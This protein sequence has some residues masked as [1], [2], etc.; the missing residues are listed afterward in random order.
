MLKKFLKELPW[1]SD[2]GI[3]E[4]AKR[5]GA[6]RRR[7]WTWKHPMLLQGLW[8]CLHRW[9]ED[10]FPPLLSL[11]LQAIWTLFP[12]RA[13]KNAVHVKC[14]LSIYIYSPPPAN[15]IL[16]ATAANIFLNIKIFYHPSQN[17][18]HHFHVQVHDCNS[19]YLCHQ[20]S[21]NWRESS[22]S[23]AILLYF[24]P[25]GLKYLSCLRRQGRSLVLV[26]PITG[27]KCQRE[28]LKAKFGLLGRGLKSPAS[29]GQAGT[30]NLHVRQRKSLYETDLAAPSL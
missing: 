5:Y 2:R 12:Q 24:K 14:L 25:S 20:P 26:G 4:L 8:A 23:E 7:R 10:L 3:R 11:R 16:Q 19:V 27:G 28:T 15:H 21:Q 1:N 29:T 13:R 22:K 18:S 9:A 6:E 30:H 17:P